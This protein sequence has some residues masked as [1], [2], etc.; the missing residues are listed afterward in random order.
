M[1][2]RWL[3]DFQYESGFHMRE[4]WGALAALAIGLAAPVAASAGSF[5]DQ[6]MD[7]LNRVRADPSGYARYLQRERAENGLANDERGD[8]RAFSEA[9]DFLKGQRPLPPLQDD[10]RL[11]SA[12]AEYARTQG[13]GGGVGHGAAG[14]LGRRIQAKGVWAGLSGE[15]IS[16]GQSTPFEVVRQLVIDFGVPDR[17][18]REMIFDRSFQA[19]GVGCGRHAAY[20]AMCVIDFAGAFPPK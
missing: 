18:H 5:E 15:T 12:A 11:A 16:Y 9:I 1:V 8:P 19:A 4:V 6:V 17:G 7:E 3:R 14:G 20:G 13:P 2:A 10:G